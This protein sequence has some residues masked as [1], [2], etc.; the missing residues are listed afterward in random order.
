[1]LTKF[2]T[3]IEKFAEP[4]MDKANMIAR[5]AGM[6]YSWTARA[7]MAME[8]FFIGGL[9]NFTRMTQGVGLKIIKGLTQNPE[10][11]KEIDQ[12]IS[13]MEES[14]ANYNRNLAA[15]RDVTIPPALTLADLGED[16]GSFLDY[17]GEALADNSPSILTTFIPAAAAI[18][19]ECY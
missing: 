8:E 1:M 7:G 12:S 15:K 3:D 4:G 2:H 16:G 17:V 10:K 9:T 19:G 18:R 11:R 5:A 14:L 6:D 13:A